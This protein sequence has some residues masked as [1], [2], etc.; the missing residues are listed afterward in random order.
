MCN[1]M[2]MMMHAAAAVY[3]IYYMC[4]SMMMR[5]AAAAVYDIFYMCNSM[6]MM[7]HAAAA[8]YSPVRATSSA[9][10]E[11][12]FLKSK[13]E[14]LE[15]KGG[16]A[17]G[18]QGEEEEDEEETDDGDDDGANGWEEVR[19]LRERVTWLEAELLQ[20]PHISPSNAPLGV[21]R[22]SPAR[23]KRAPPV[24]PAASAPHSQETGPH[25]RAL[26]TRA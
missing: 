8:A 7:R 12:E 11:V 19:R 9:E 16:G 15:G 25:N 3:D 26:L 10:R 14:L 18:R 17:G 21:P 5:H 6:M 1:S 22:V 4:N 13:V 2:M 20:V 23:W 24:E